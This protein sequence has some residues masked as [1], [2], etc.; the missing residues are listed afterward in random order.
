[1]IR[2]RLH[3]AYW[4]WR[5]ELQVTLRA[6]IVYAIGGLFLAVQGIAFAGL[7]SA[8]ADPRRPAPLGALLEGQLAGTLLTWVLQLVVLTLLGM[9]AIADDKRSGAWEL[10]LTARVSERGAVIGKWLA[11]VTIYA[12]LWIPTLAYLA[13]VAVFRVDEGGWD[14]ASIVTGYV[15]AIAVG[16]ALLAWTV[17]ASAAA[18]TTLVAGAFG[19][20]LLIGLFLLGELPASFPELATD[21]PALA[22]MLDTL[23]LRG[24]LTSFARGELAA[25]SI[26]FVVGLAVTGLSLAI[27]LAC[28]GRRRR[29]EL[30]NRFAATAL[31]AA[32]AILAGHLA[33]RFQLRWDASGR[34]SLDAETVALLG[35][36]PGPA[37]LTIVK[38][39]LAA[40]EPI[41]VEVE[42]V[43]DRMADAGPVR[44]RVVDPAALPGGLE[45]AARAAGVSP[46]DLASNGGVVVEVGGKR[47]VVDRLQLVSITRDDQGTA[48]VGRIAIEQ[49]ITGAFAQL[50]ATVPVTACAT[51][52][53]GEIPLDHADGDADW[54]MVADRLRG[55]GIDVDEVSLDH[56]V[57]ARC[58]VVIV[59]GPTTP[60]SPAE[61]LSIQTFVRRGGGLVV[62]AAARPV[63]GATTASAP[64]TTLASTGLEG[65]LAPE[66]LGLPPA[67]AVDPSLEM[68]ELR[69][70]LLVFDGYARH[71]IN[72][73]FA[74]ARGTIWFQPR[75]VVTTGTARPLVRAT[76]AS[77]G[78]R[79][80]VD[81]PAKDLDDLAGPVVFAALGQSQRVVA[82][83]SAESFMTTLLAGS[84]SAADLWLAHAVRFV[85]G[86]PAPKVSVAARA[87]EQV[88]LVMTTGQRR[89]VLVLSIAGIPL[90]WIVVGAGLLIARRRRA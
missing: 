4:V 25:T 65:V 83:G 44:V 15:G 1:M 9:R 88:R 14:V 2:N 36:L 31:L 47:R 20:A 56:G 70:S 52:G 48:A 51:T 40:L 3:S 71:A 41:Y 89:A 35:E 81:P 11:A 6:P 54:R 63:T 24:E 64:T 39:T 76:A 57:P 78:E 77:W 43:A 21:H 66:G 72:D 59:A 23:S 37:T 79:D 67:I 19:F 42:R 86:K 7:V 17:A 18:T 61:A 29:S 73:G 12:L 45:A 26:L 84:A 49:A 34:N 50:V 30:R 53:H 74:Q 82:V 69:G 55:D 10:L 58:N 27:A 90:L 16:A 22:R 87:P 46:A 62:A 28:V 85:A 13:V 60:L 38:P 32:I 33:G 5:R 75:V 8:L 80:L 68:R